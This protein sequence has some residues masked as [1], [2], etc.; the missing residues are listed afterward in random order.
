M[1]S[2]FILFT[3]L[4]FSSCSFKSPPNKWQYES[5]NAFDSYTQNFLSSNDTLAKENLNRAIQHAKKSADLTMLARIYLGEC[6]LNISVD[7]K[8]RCDKY[9]NISD[10]VNDKALDAYYKFITQ[11]LNESD[12]KHL[13]Q[14]YKK[15]ALLLHKKEFIK[16]QNEISNISKD[17]SKLIAASLIKDSIDSQTRDKIIK[18]ASF[19]GYK[20][21][22]LFWLNESK[23]NTIDIDKR[24][25]IIKK[26]SILESNE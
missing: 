21:S 22:V 6:A 15:F 7:M 23:K 4:L 3:L 16:A 5:S 18:I 20:K 26:I 8:D 10:L 2:I 17:T 24:N 14:S 12:I 11:Q 19:N 25:Q 9:T 13:K 1:Q